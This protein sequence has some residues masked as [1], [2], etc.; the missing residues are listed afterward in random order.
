MGEKHI[1]QERSCHLENVTCHDCQ[2]N[3]VAKLG[4]TGPESLCLSSTPRTHAK[5]EARLFTDRIMKGVMCHLFF[6]YFYP[7]GSCV[8]PRHDTDLAALLSPS[9]LVRGNIQGRQV[10][11]EM[12]FHEETGCTEA[13]PLSLCFLLVTS[14]S[15]RA[16]G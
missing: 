5:K 8:F 2:G 14:V 3:P 4:D 16:Q 6:D 11:E 12:L 15:G 9:E 1:K 10:F 13:L 7:V